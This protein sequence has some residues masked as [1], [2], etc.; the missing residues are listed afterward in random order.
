MHHKIVVVVPQSY[1][2]M[3]NNLNNLRRRLKYTANKLI[4]TT[5]SVDS[6]LQIRFK[7]QSP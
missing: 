3:K 7:Y 1:P 2:L 6:C 5:M 4:A